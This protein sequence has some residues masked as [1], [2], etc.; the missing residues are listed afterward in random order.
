MER[1]ERPVLN[2]NW[3]IYSGLLTAFMFA[4]PITVYC[5]DSIFKRFCAFHTRALNLHGKSARSLFGYAVSISLVYSTVSLHL[6]YY[7]LLKIVGIKSIYELE[8][9]VSNQFIEHYEGM[10]D[11]DE[12]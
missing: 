7:A 11:D 1:K 9:Y 6:Y 10:Y 2:P 5:S 12:E 3:P 8:G 4:V